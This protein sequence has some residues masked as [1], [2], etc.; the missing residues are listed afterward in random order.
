MYIHY[1]VRIRPGYH[2]TDMT[3]CFALSV[4]LRIHSEH[5]VLF[6]IFR[7]S[8]VKIMADRIKENR[9]LLLTKLRELG[10]PGD[11]SHI[12]KQIGMFSYTG[13]D[14]KYF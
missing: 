11:W 13:L 10:T 7:K 3:D 2:G 4:P 8:Q 1:L 9:S 5:S 14:S 6:I 12:T